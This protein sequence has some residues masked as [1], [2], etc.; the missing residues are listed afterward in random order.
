VHQP[1][2]AVDGHGHPI[3]LDYQGASVPKRM[4]QLGYSGKAIRGV[5]RIKDDTG[6]LHV[7]AMDGFGPIAPAGTTNGH[8]TNGH[9]T[10]GHSTD[11]H[12]TEGHSTVHG[13]RALTSG[14]PA[15]PGR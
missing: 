7:E 6:Q 3:P 15:A 8:P 13:D 11:G 2:G 12:T 14:D 10:D 9:T 5:M 1:L 4:N